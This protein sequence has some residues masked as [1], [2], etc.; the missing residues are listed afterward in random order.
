[1]REV[2]KKILILTIA[3]LLLALPILTI[4]SVQAKSSPPEILKWT[5]R[6][7]QAWLEVDTDD[8]YVEYWIRVQ[9]YFLN[10]PGE[11]PTKT[12]TM[13]ISSSGL[14]CTKELNPSEF[15][16]SFGSCQLSTEALGLPL[17]IEWNTDPPT[18]TWHMSHVWV[19]DHYVIV[20]GKGRGI[21]FDPLIYD[22]SVVAYWGENELYGVGYV[23]HYSTIAITP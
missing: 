8:G 15:K 21:E 6:V 22:A 3:L 23:A 9:E 14:I 5:A 10:N 1:M 11:P 18:N 12:M 16:W 19:V 2:N 17:T 4:S 20:N 7:A 13:H